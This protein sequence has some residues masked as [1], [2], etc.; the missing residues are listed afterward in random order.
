MCILLNN[1]V[2]LCILLSFLMLNDLSLINLLNCRF[3]NNSLWLLLS[4]ILCLDEVIVLSLIKA[5]ACKCIHEKLLFSDAI[6]N[7]VLDVILNVAFYPISVL[8]VEDGLVVVD[9]VVLVLLPVGCILIVHLL[10]WTL[11][12]S[13]HTWRFIAGH[14]L[15]VQVLAFIV[16]ALVVLKELAL[17]LLNLLGCKSL[18]PE[19]WSILLFL[20]PFSVEVW[21][22]HSLEDLIDNR[23]PCEWVFVFVVDLLGCGVEAFR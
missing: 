6:W 4:T 9:P 8:L 1:L 21:L 23:L 2:S 11:S 16:L 20:L 7:V 14:V 5:G 10:I 18:H 19:L 15:V 17:L 22:A 12:I 3:L 13:L